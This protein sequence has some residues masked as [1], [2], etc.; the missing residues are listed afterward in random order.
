MSSFRPSLRAAVTQTVLL[1]LSSWVILRLALRLDVRVATV[2]TVGAAAVLLAIRLAWRGP[3]TTVRPGDDALY[4]EG[5]WGSRRIAWSSVLGMRL[6]AGEVT[7]REGTV[8]VCYAHV[9]VAHGPPLAFADLSSL[10][11]ARL[12]TPDGAAPVHDVG[13]PELLLG[14]I[15]E[16][17]DAR[18]F[19]PT[20]PDTDVDEG[21]RLGLVPSFATTLRLGVVALAT[22]RVLERVGYD[23]D[24][25]L[26]A[27]AGAMVVAVAHGLARFVAQRRGGDAQSEVGAP[28]AVM[29]GCAAAVA[30][31][32]LHPGVLPSRVAAWA[33]SASLLAVFPSWPMPGGYVARRAGRWFA[34]ARDE[35]TAVAL[36]A[37]GVFTAW[38]FARGLM[39]LPMALV[40]GG[41]EAAEG[42]H[43]SRRHAHLAA[44]PR[45]RA[46]SAEGL[47]R[48]RALLRPLPPREFDAHMG[49]GDVAELRRARATPPPRGG[50]VL[51]AYALAALAAALVQRAA[52]A[53]G[54]PGVAAAI[55]WLVT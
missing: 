2:M 19:L 29:A 25:L 52:L 11:P 46:W 27:L 30:L 45:F 18:E 1:A 54:D 5:P 51:L 35:V 13:D 36:A 22:S 3:Q 41:F 15:A 32:W 31:W 21:P 12:E 26:A 4:V 28:P 42:Y 23:H 49:P 10:G 7:T 47:A 34:S 16:H 6:A 20:A 8:R 55:R 33:L 17:A 38:L 39:L 43:A 24:A 40:A 14:V 53:G 48:W 50:A 44:L 9:D 37:A